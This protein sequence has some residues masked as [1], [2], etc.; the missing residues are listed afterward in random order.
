MHHRAR[1]SASKW[2]KAYLLQVLLDHEGLVAG[3]RETADGVHQLKDAMSVPVNAVGS[4]GLMG[5]R[6]ALAWQCV[7]EEPPPPPLGWVQTPYPPPPLSFPSLV[8]H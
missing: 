4:M 3:G 1:A 6:A 7:K 8:L 2:H 5:L